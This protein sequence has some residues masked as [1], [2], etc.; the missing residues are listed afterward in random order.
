MKFLLLPNDSFSRSP[1][2]ADCRTHQG[3]ARCSL[4]IDG[5]KIPFILFV[6]GNSVFIGESLRTFEQMLIFDV[7]F[8]ESSFVMFPPY[9]V[10]VLFALGHFHHELGP[11]PILMS[12]RGD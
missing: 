6:K 8:L 5:V 11:F 1:F 2:I 7:G 9:I 12:Y 3:T 10:N 4:D